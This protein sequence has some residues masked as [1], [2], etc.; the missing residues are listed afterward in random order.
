MAF[1]GFLLGF[2]ALS[3]NP[4]LPLQSSA[5]LSCL[6]TYSTVSFLHHQHFHHLSTVV[7]I[8]IIVINVV[9]GS[10]LSSASLASAQLDVLLLFCL[11][12]LLLACA[13]S[14]LHNPRLRILDSVDLQE[15]PV[16]EVE[17]RLVGVESALRGKSLALNPTSRHNPNQTISFNPEPATLNS[18]DR[19]Y[20][21]PCMG[22][23]P[24]RSQGWHGRRWDR[25]PKPRQRPQPPRRV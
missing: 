16:R 24:S 8:I 11:Q 19:P 12:V 13:V 5:S 15:Q 20:R 21:I 7:I 6:W 22:T 9:S 23:L 1:T 10:A 2:L 4:S 17:F 25:L 14:C 3:S 18:H